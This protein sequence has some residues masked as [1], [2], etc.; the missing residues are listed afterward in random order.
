MTGRVHLGI[1]AKLTLSYVGLFL[2]T[3]A[4]LLAVVALFILRYI[5]NA[6]LVVSVSGEWAP[7]RQDIFEAFAPRAA[8]VIVVLFGVALGVSWFLAGRILRPLPGLTRA[9]Q[10]TS[11]G[12]LTHRIRYA[13]ARD[14]LGRLADTFDD[15][16]A[17]LQRHD[18]QQ[19]RFAAN[20]SHELRTPL[21]ATRALLDVAEADPG[22]LDTGDLLERLRRI[23]EHAI[24]TT[25]A[26]LVMA[27]SQEGQLPTERVDLSLVAE[28]AVET[29]VPVAD[30]RRVT[31]DADGTG[32][33]PCSGSAPLLLQMTQNLLHNAIVH[34]VD[35][36]R[37]VIRTGIEGGHA[38][39]EVVNTGP[40]V[41]EEALPTLTDA[42]RRVDDRGRSGHAAGAGLGLS[43]VAAIV[44]AHR[45]SLELGARDGGGLRVR[46]DLP[47]L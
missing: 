34:N 45:G 23:N 31:L 10:L 25:E 4:V 16:L 12:S 33:A 40:V 26:M 24:A 7:G 28:E 43:V 11:Q 8:V 21:A 1:R 37:V 42:F 3:T 15:M 44:R 18:D 38:W 46:V 39:V 27:R 17:Q 32:A 19:R 9:A 30:R 29:L 22:S 5:P 13:G 20:A 41:P 35:G 47:A 2:G 14:E 6:G 36:G